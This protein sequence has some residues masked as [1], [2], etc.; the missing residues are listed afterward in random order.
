MYAL[1][2]LVVV[3]SHCSASRN[4]VGRQL[5]EGSSQAPE[6]AVKHDERVYAQDCGRLDT[7]RRGSVVAALKAEWGGDN[8]E[9]VAGI[10]GKRG[11]G[12]MRPQEQD[13]R[14]QAYMVWV[15]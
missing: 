11:A 3:S 4:K 7:G 10:D 8:V 6:E 2:L 15:Y 5:S 12:D 9:R 14:V 13:K 1:K